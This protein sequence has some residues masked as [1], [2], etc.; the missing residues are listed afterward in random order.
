MAANSQ[1]LKYVFWKLLLLLKDFHIK[2]GGLFLGSLG[3][4]F[5]STL[6]TIFMYSAWSCLLFLLLFCILAWI[7]WFCCKKHLVCV[8]L[9]LQVPNT[10]LWWIWTCDWELCFA[11]KV[12]EKNHC[13]WAWNTF[14]R[15][16]TFRQMVKVSLNAA[17]MLNL[18]SSCFCWICWHPVYHF[19]IELMCNFT[20]WC[21]F[22][23]YKWSFSKT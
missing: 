19:N 8:S 10:W 6:C 13:N 21:S 17:N 12:A 1:E 3:H 16:M 22:S 15:C 18:L 5:P 9:N 23:A 14:V 7:L 20:V 11:Q 4:S 2:L